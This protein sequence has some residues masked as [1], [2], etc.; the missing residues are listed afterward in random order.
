MGDVQR[1]VKCNDGLAQIM[2]D[3]QPLCDKCAGIPTLAE[4]FSTLDTE[5]KNKMADLYRHKVLDELSKL[6]SPK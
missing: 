3:G 1:C 2:Q 6:R 5:L 4:R